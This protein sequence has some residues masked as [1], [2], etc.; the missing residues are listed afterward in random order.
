MNRRAF[1]QKSF[2]ASSLIATSQFPFSA[3]AKATHR[4]ETLSILHTNDVHSRLEA[5][6]MD[7]SKYQGMGGIKARYQ[8]IQA[9]RKQQANTLL[10]DAGDMFQGTP[11]FNFYKGKPE[12]EAMNLMGYD[13]A[14]LGNHDFDNGIDGLA[15]QLALAKFAIVN[16]N[17]DVSNTALSP[18]VKPY[19][20]IKKGDIK[21]GILGV[22]IE[23][24]GLVPDHLCKGIVYKNP[25]E[26]ANKVAR[27]LK[28]KKKCDYIMCLSHLGYEYGNDKVSDQTLASQSEQIHLILGGHTHTFLDKPYTTKNRKNQEVIINQ[29]GWAGL[30][31]GVIK[32]FFNHNDDEMG[33]SD[34]TV[35][36]LKET[37][38]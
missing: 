35:I 28:T 3:I 24:K 12:I 1:L 6:P 2:V 16:C 27:F 5:F 23:L 21:I 26:E 36:P 38:I 30:Q 29:V 19:T 4:R 14:T 11:Y 17:Y 15:K 22:G 37:M 25:I 18:F 32:I 13:A 20:I 9:L 8:T 7:G 31:L 10:L 33:I 34:T